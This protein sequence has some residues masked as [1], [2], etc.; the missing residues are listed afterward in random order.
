MRIRCDLGF[1]AL[2]AWALLPAA[3]GILRSTPAAAD[4]TIP[5]G[6]IQYN[7]KNGNNGQGGWDPSGS[8]DIQMK[9]LVGK[10]KDPANPAPVQFI[11][12]VQAPAPLISK[13]LAGSPYNITDWQTI[14]GGCQGR[15]R[16][17]NL[18]TEGVQIAYFSKDWELVPNMKQNPLANTIKSDHCFDSGRPYNL[19]YFQQKNATGFKVLFVLI[20]PPHCYDF[21]ASGNPDD[22]RA[23]I[24]TK[25]YLRKF[26][27]FT[28]EVLAAT[29]SS[30]A[31]LKNL[32]V[33][34]VGDTNE[35]GSR[36]LTPPGKS[37]PPYVGTPGG[38]ELIF[39]DFGPIKVSQIE[40][41]TCSSANNETN[42]TCCSNSSH[43]QY[44]F[45]RIVVNHWVDDPVASIIDTNAYPFFNGS[46]E[47]K[48]IYGVVSFPAPK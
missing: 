32:N 39:P 29:G 15:D 19:A 35:L 13:V 1:R 21:Y 5:I 30:A 28:S 8:L 10:I 24:K 45:D 18:Y 9:M 12:L 22:L 23:C 6:I 31:D 36:G 26:G 11:T 16:N 46:E 20:H 7:A 47:H 27:N 33:V 42:G 43:W 40:G 3:L 2:R 38:Y 41:K 44:F 34:V 37:C 17:G 14:I 25:G 48:A 4:S